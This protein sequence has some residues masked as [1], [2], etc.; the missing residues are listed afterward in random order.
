MIML[1]SNSIKSDIWVTLL[2]ICSVTLYTANREV[3]REV[4]F[5]FLSATCRSLTSV[6]PYGAYFFGCVMYNRVDSWCV[7]GSVVA[8]PLS[9]DSLSFTLG[10]P[11]LRP[12]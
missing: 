5:P 9:P 11:R 6:N 3:P 2:V 8:L 10:A 7:L 12:E 1:K 4:F